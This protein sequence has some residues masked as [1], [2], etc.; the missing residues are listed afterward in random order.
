MTDKLETNLSRS[1]ALAAKCIYATMQI[2][3][4]TPIYFLAPTE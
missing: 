2:L 1:R 3:P 4:L